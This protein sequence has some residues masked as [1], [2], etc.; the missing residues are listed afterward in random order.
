ML[1]KNLSKNNIIVSHVEKVT[2][3]WKRLS[4]LIPYKTMPQD[5]GLWIPYC[6]SIHSYLMNFEFDAVFVDK[7][8]RV[9]KCVS[10][11]KPNQLLW[12][13]FGARAVIELNPGVIQRHN[14]E[15]G[16]QLHVV[17]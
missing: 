6:N 16:D 5:F 2:S 7:N 9:K 3:F 13:V 11:I 12:P 17:D 8:F 15:I 14:I 4:G 10:N 1:L